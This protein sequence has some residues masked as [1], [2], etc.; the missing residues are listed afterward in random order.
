MQRE[1][2]ACDGSKHRSDT[3]SRVGIV[4]TSP[5]AASIDTISMNELDSEN[6]APQCNP[7][8]LAACENSAEILLR[9]ASFATAGLPARDVDRAI[10]ILA[11]QRTYTK[12]HH[13]G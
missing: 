5:H 8:A 1:Y 2:S 10:A 4:A 6:M 12:A 7:P 13:D 3:A 11:R 9:F